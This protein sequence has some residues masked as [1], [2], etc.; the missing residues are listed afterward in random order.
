MQPAPTT[1]AFALAAV[2]DVRSGMVVGLGTGRTSDRA[3]RALAQRMREDHLDIDCVCTSNSTEKLALEL[4]LPVI[5]FGEVEQVDY[6]I[7]GCSEVDHELRM[8][9]GQF[10]AIA[11]QR[12]VAQASRRRVYMVGEDKVVNKLGTN[13]LLSVTII[14]FGVA[15]IRNRLRDLGLSGVVRRGLDGEVFATDGGNLVLDMSLPDRDIVDLATELDHVA[16]VVDHGIF[17]N[18]ADEVLVECKNGDVRR[19]VRPG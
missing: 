12:L 7:D 19:L 11:R 15:S 9:K 4:A 2:A 18:E 16:G 14:A 5:P 10:G 1:D 17:L 13:A 6:L 3:T 8:L